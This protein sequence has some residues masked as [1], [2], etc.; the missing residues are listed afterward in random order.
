MLLICFCQ[1]FPPEC[2]FRGRF[3]LGIFVWSFLQVFSCDLL[4]HVGDFCAFA[5]SQLFGRRLRDDGFSYKDCESSAPE[6][7]NPGPA[8]RFC[9]SCE[10]MF[11]FGYSFYFARIAAVWRWSLGRNRGAGTGWRLHQISAAV[12]LPKTLP[13]APKL[14]DSEKQDRSKLC[15]KVCGARVTWDGLAL[16]GPSADC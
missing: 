10:S 13:G 5:C 2:R 16:A 1:T 14:S 15:C 4:L 12:Q 8:W 6:V 11:L 3:F 9:C 7:G